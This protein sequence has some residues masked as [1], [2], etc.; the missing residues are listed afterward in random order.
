[1][2]KHELCW[3]WFFKGFKHALKEPQDKMAQGSLKSIFDEMF[4][5]VEK[6]L[7]MYELD[8]IEEI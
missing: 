4:N 5:E 8:Q 6:L 1:M 3:A 2:N 7:E